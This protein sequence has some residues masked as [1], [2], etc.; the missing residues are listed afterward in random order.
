[1]ADEDPNAKTGKLSL[2]K[3]GLEAFRDDRL[4]PFIDKLKDIAVG[5]EDLGPSMPDLVGEKDYSTQADL[6]AYN[7]QKPL[8][9][10]FMLSKDYLH[11]LGEQLNT[12][13]LK[14]ATDLTGIFEEQTKLFDDIME[15]LQSSLEQLFSAQAGNLQKIDGQ[16]FLDIFEDVVTDM[17]GQKGGS[18]ENE[19]E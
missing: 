14:T 10:G 4:Q 15:N 11:G 6:D 17:G 8:Q 1:M 7:L 16:D 19:E 12:E 13:I 9:L 5:K 3:A 18:G 2:D